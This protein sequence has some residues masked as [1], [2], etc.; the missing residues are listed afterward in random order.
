MPNTIQPI[1]EI[2][3]TVI[4][5]YN[6]RHHLQPFSTLICFVQLSSILHHTI[7]LFCI[8]IF[9]AD[10]LLLIY[11]FSGDIIALIFSNFRLFEVRDQLNQY[12]STQ[13]CYV[14]IHH[15]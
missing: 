5:I 9:F 1:L 8:P 6:V 12:T 15:Y 13:Y 11:I 3:I 2:C 14:E 4:I 10:F 7:E